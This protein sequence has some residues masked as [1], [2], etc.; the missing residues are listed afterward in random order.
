MSPPILTHTASTSA[1]R[2]RARRVAPRSRHRSITCCRSADVARVV[3]SSHTLLNL[4]PA[5]G[6]DESHRP[7]RFGRA[8]AGEHLLLGAV[9]SDPAVTH[10]STNGVS[11][12]C[13]QFSSSWPS[14]RSRS[15]SSAA[16]GA[17]ASERVAPF[18]ARPQQSSEQPQATTSAGGARRTP[19]SRL[20]RDRSIQSEQREGVVPPAAQRGRA[21]TGTRP[22][23][24][25][26]SCRRG[27]PVWRYGIGCP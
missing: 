27:P 13:G 5:V 25:Q 23:I 4:R 7:V 12:C 2:A 26:I 19:G 17:V 16:S 1:I 3:S 9:G 11:Q 21:L 10:P 15:S 22:R 24:D 6:G 8:R 20:L 18:R 14:S